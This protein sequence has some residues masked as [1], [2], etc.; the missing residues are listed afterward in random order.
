MIAALHDL[1]VEVVM[2]TSC[3][4]HILVYHQQCRRRRK[5]R[6]GASLT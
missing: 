1:G 5:L 4:L 2:L 3:H 6:V